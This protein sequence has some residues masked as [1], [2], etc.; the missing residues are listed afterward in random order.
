MRSTFI[1]FILSSLIM[2]SLSGCG[3]NL[4]APDDG[5]NGGTPSDSVSVYQNVTESNLPDGLTG[6]TTGVTAGDFDDDGDFDLALAINLGTSRLLI[7]DGSGTF[8]SQLL[9]NQSYDSRDIITGY[10]NSD[11][12]LDLFVVNYSSQITSNLYLNDGNGSFSDFSNRISV[13]GGFTSA[14]ASDINNDGSTDILIGNEG[15]N[16]LLM[17][18]GNGF[19]ND[20]GIQRLPQLYDVTQDL[21]FGD[22]TG[23]GLLDIVVANLDANKVLIN[24]GSGFFRDQSTRYPYLNQNEESRKVSLVD[25]DNDNDL[26]LYVGNATLNQGANRQDR[27]LINNGNGSFTD[28]TSN[29][30][31]TINANTLAAAFADLDNDGDPDLVI[32]DYSGGLS[33]LLNNGN[34]FF[35]NKTTDW[36][37]D[38]YTPL[39]MDIAIADFNNDGLVDLYLA[40]RGGQDQLLLQKSE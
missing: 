31:P 2:I 24:T 9:T 20:Q 30:L 16:R 26:D 23:D 40:V 33:I 38:N 12:Y 13:T 11:S 37:P 36:L 4:N 15:Q 1:I 25:V 14:E 18:T 21:T 28:D 29:R 27:L 10:L 7:N 8:S 6:T 39:V 17:N 3:W 22:I 35:T 19:F 5:N 32:G 34:G